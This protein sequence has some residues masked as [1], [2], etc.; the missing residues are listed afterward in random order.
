MRIL[1]AFALALMAAAAVLYFHSRPN[2][3]EDPRRVQTE[4]VHSSVTAVEPPRE[5][6]PAAAQRE[7]L[8][9]SPS[10]KT[11]TAQLVV[12][13]RRKATRA[14]VAG[15]K[16]TAYSDRPVSDFSSNTLEMA[17]Q[18]AM[19]Q[20]DSAG[21]VVLGIRVDEPLMVQAELPD[22]A[23]IFESAF[24]IAGLAAGARSETEILLP[25][26]ND[27]RVFGQVL[28][29]ET[30]AP[31]AGARVELRN[32]QGAADRGRAAY[33][34]GADGKFEIPFS[35]WAYPHL[36]VE[37]AGCGARLANPAGHDDPARPLLVRLARACTLEVVARDPAG[38]PVAS[39]QVWLT[40]KC[41]AL[42]SAA[43]EASGFFMRAYIYAPDGSWS[44]ETG[45]DGRATFAGLPAEV[46]L[47]AQVQW[48]RTRKQVDPEHITLAPGETRRIE[49]L[50]R[51]STRLRGRLLDQVGTPLPRRAILIAAPNPDPRERTLQLAG[52]RTR[53]RVKTDGLGEFVV[54]GLE[55]GTWLVAPDREGGLE[56][57]L[58]ACMPERVVTSGEPEV[59]MTLH[60]FRDVYLTGFVLDPDAKPVRN[61]RVE[62]YATGEMFWDD[63]RTREDG[64]FR[65]GPVT[66]DAFTLLAY[67]QD[68]LA[69][70]EALSARA[71]DTGIVLYLEPGGV[72]RGRVV[73]AASGA[74]CAAQLMYTPERRGFGP[75]GSGAMMSTEPDGSFDIRG[76]VAGR[77]GL[78][79]LTADGRFALQSGVEVAVGAQTS[80]IQLSLA[81]GGKLALHYTGAQP[82]L[83]VTVTHAGV[84]VHFGE[85][86]APGGRVTVLAPAGTLRLELRTDP[87][88]AARTRELELEAG[89]TKEIALTDED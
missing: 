23:P 78:S 15:V 2:A 28:S 79:A 25:D 5:G 62:A 44:A 38:A 89:E 84:P 40:A 60:A 27:S 72:L 42:D 47:H 37:A 69:N 20:T 10:S 14:P 3:A 17:E 16:V 1:L 36:Y 82:R 68:G 54:D 50:F 26:E 71:F 45:D 9:G 35:S 22:R 4:V 66:G 81:P 30:N 6:L 88:G 41:A 11:A 64:R 57:G 80:G 31:L 12:H 65:L 33:T 74:G 87:L 19:G 8:A 21:N 52:P 76:L 86:L 77:Y 67:G 70:S 39:V 32:P 13:V 63:A 18:L 51:G 75:F 29:A 85:Q 56:D 58:L 61:A 59:S 46:E 34:T 49:V 83:F 53:A 24:G 55:P 48:Q 43:N 73:D 7:A